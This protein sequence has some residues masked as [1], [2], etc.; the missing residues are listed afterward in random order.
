MSIRLEERIA[1]LV[2]AAGI[3]WAAQVATS[4]FTTINNVFLPQ[5]PLE[6]CGVGILTWLHAKYRRSISMK[7][8]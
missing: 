7:R 3:V 4:H 8:V 5:G 2:A 1:S 6:I